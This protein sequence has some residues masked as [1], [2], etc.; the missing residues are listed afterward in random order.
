MRIAAEVR[1]GEDA[2]NTSSAT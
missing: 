2:Q 1:R